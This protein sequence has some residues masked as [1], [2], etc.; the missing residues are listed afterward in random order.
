[1]TN[2]DNLNRTL[3][4]KDNLPILRGID[5]DSVDLIATD[6]PFNKGVG[7]FK[8]KT[9][10]GRGLSYKDVWS[11]DD[12]VQPEWETSIS[13]EHPNLY[14]SIKAAN[15]TAGKDMGAYLCWIAVR[16]LEMHRVLKPIGSI[17]LHCDPTASHY[18][19]AMMDGIFGRENFRNEIVWHHPKIGVA[20]ERFTANTDT[21]FYYSKGK[22]YTFNPQT[23]GEPNELFNRWKNKIID[24]KL[25]Y[26]QAKTI[27]DSPAAFKISAQRKRL[28]RELQDDDVVIDFT[29]SIN[30]KRIDN[31]WLYP[32]I[33]GNSKESSG[34]PTQKPLALYKRII[35]ASTNPGDMV[36]DPFAG[37]ATTCVAA[38]QL[39]R[40]WIGID[41]NLEAGDVIHKRLQ[42]E[43]SASMDWNDSV[44]V[45]YNAPVRTDGSLNH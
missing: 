43:V 33:R 27:R 29:E 28:G 21:I 39:G 9:K 31:V 38:E 3:F 41:N 32:F 5:S 40:R 45:L 23:T 26:K 44:H 1:M 13:K 6:P 20:A 16:L 30:E 22:E 11:W 15:G 4:L 24:N 34:Y 8:G 17:Y 10:E 35:E 2:A 7:A 42:D 25:Y 19:K 36:L 12:D 14:R 18:L 37:W